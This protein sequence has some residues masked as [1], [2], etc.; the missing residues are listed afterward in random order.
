MLDLII[1]TFRFKL[2][3]YLDLHMR[4]QHSAFPPKPRQKNPCTVCGKILSSQ[5]ALR[6]HEE[7]HRF[8]DQPDEQVKKFICDD[9]GRS[10]RLKSYLFNHLHNVHIRAKHVCLFCSKG[11]YKRYELSDHVRQYHTMEKPFL[12]E[13]AG[14]TK[15]F[16]RKKNLMIHQRIHTG[17]IAFLI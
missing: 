9:C 17:T 13:H 1:N 15:T 2:H 14:C 3:E 8:A 5:V 7:R 11:F 4:N 10:F 16:A 12:C 6:N